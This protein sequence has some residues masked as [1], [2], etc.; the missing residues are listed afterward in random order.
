MGLFSWIRRAT[1]DD[2]RDE[3]ICHYVP[4]D[5]SFKKYDERVLR[6]MREGR[7]VGLLLMV[8]A[9]AQEPTVWYA[10]LLGDKRRVFATFGPDYFELQR[11]D[12]G[13]YLPPYESTEC[14]VEWVPAAET[15]EFLASRGLTHED[16]PD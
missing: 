16:F 15:A 11:I 7:E 2:F 14:D 12:Q 6:L 9:W 10:E 1:G 4:A 3:V 13:S 8:I 5:P